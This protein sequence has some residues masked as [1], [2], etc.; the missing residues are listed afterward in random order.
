M[1]KFEDL[2]DF[3][4]KKRDEFFGEEPSF[5][6]F[7][8]FAKKLDGIHEEPNT[9]KSKPKL[10]SY[11]MMVGIVAILGFFTIPF[12]PQVTKQQGYFSNQ[13]N[14]K[15]I[16]EVDQQLSS[17]IRES[18]SNPVMQASFANNDRLQVTL[19]EVTEL[20]MQYVKLKQ[21]YNTT[22]HCSS[23]LKAMT[24]NLEKRLAI[25]DCLNKKEGKIE[26]NKFVHEY[27]LLNQPRD[28]H[29]YLTMPDRPSQTEF[30]TS[31]QYA[32]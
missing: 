13:T 12:I 3:F 22:N 30:F 7:N 4:E 5:G 25:L 23:V 6:H 16:D 28:F 9:A 19:N 21:Q 10:W 29:G 1:K 27:Y 26:E 17:S 32:Y 20:E 8:R 11:G 15:S 14:S 24:N 2:E 31:V 18:L